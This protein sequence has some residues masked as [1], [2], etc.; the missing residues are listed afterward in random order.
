MV[1]ALLPPPR[2]TSPVDDAA[3]HCELIIAGA[4]DDGAVDLAA[5]NLD[6]IVAVA[7]VDGDAVAGVNVAAIPDGDVGVRAQDA[8]ASRGCDG[9]AVDDERAPRRF[10]RLDAPCVGTADV[11][12]PTVDHR[13]V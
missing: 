1:K 13:A 4:A 9:S 2:L 10:G 11:D 5:G 12:R 8:G 3:A 7:E 6:D